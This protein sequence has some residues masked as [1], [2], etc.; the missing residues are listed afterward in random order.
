MK[1]IRTMKM[2]SFTIKM[3]HDK[4]AIEVAE[5]AIL[6]VAIVVVGYGVYTLLG[7]KIAQV[8]QSVTS[9]I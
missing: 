9:A 8:V 1:G 4:R 6:L 3:L 7:A 2:K 5:V